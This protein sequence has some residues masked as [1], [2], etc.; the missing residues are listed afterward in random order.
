MLGNLR[1]HYGFHEKPPEYG[2]NFS[3]HFKQANPRKGQKSL[4]C[5]FMMFF[6]KMG[7]SLSSWVFSIMF[8]FIFLALKLGIGRSNLICFS[9]EWVE[10]TKPDKHS[11]NVECSLFLRICGGDRYIKT[12]WFAGLPKRKDEQ[13]LFIIGQLPGKK[14]ALKIKMQLL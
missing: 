7:G 3:K 12:S 6:C 13:C 4:E 2:C 10:T 5:C 9:L 8:W 14:D 11:V 1:S